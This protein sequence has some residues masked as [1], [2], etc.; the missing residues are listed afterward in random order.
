MALLLCLAPPPKTDLFSRKRVAGRERQPRYIPVQGTL[1]GG[2][3]SQ[4]RLPVF[5]IQEGGVAPHPNEFSEQNMARECAP[6]PQSAPL[7]PRRGFKH[8]WEGG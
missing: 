8:K 1:L 5:Q 7:L 6:P 2:H 4:V 3:N